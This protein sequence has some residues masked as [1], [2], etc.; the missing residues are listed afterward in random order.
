M[1]ANLSSEKLLLTLWVG[2]L[3][4]IGYLAVPM[5]F[6]TIPDISIAGDYAGKLFLAVNMLG[7]SCGVVLL[8]SKFVSFGRQTIGLWRVWILLVM[9]SF[10]LLF[11]TYLQPEIAAVKQLIP[12]GNDADLE[13][14][15]F[16]HMISKNIYMLVSLLGLAL[17]VSTD[18]V[19]N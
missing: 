10:T 3:W 11:I 15:S 18:K 12:Q 13:R 14:F 4:A 2:S 5:A 17:V 7:L 8:I 19:E 6:A 1:M 16:F 9:L